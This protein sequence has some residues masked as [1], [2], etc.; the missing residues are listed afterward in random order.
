MSSAP[1]AHSARPLLSPTPPVHSP[2]RQ[3]SQAS[4]DTAIPQQ[5]LKV[6]VHHFVRH[7]PVFRH[8]SDRCRSR[9][10]HQQRCFAKHIIFSQFP[11]QNVFHVYL[12][13]PPVL[14]H[15]EHA[16]PG[17]TLRPAKRGAFLT[18]TRARVRVKSLVASQ[19]SVTLSVTRLARS[20]PG[21][22][23]F[24]SSFELS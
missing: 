3:I 12:E 20:P 15:C 23:S 17:V 10:I 5:A 9:P 18:S 21:T 1:L 8:A 13:L 24:P 19:S 7:A 6:V 2:S 16:I 4:F 14:S 22:R 11:N